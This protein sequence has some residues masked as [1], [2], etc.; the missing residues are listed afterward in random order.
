MPQTVKAPAI[1]SPFA[2]LPKKDYM[3]EQKQG[4]NGQQT[5]SEKAILKRKKQSNYPPVI[6]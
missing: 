4:E 2:L 3:K 6:K 5:L 1:F